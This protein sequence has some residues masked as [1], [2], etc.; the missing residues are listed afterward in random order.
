MR[1]LFCQLFLAIACGLFAQLPN[2]APETANLLPAG[3]SLRFQLDTPG[4]ESAGVLQEGDRLHFT[5][6]ESVRISHE[7]GIPAGAKIEGFV[8]A[9]DVPDELGKQMVWFQL[10]GVQ[11]THQQWISLDSNARM[12]SRNPNRVWTAR[13]RAPV[14]PE[15][16]T[17]SAIK[18]SR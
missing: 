9:A 12:F 10:S 14:L 4:D 8:C 7:L 13:L 16:A 17:I 11:S 3:I 2:H 15:T 6:V 5:V 18:A 1:Y